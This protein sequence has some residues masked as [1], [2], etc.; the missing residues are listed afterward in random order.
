MDEKN[1]EYAAGNPAD[2]VTDPS[3]PD[4]PSAA[5]DKRID[6]EYH[7]AVAV[8]SKVLRSAFN[9]RVC[10]SDNKCLYPEV[11][12]KSLAEDYV[13]KHDEQ[14]RHFFEAGASAERERVNGLIYAALPKLNG[15][16]KWG[17]QTCDTP[18]SPSGEQYVMV[19]TIDG[20]YDTPLEA[21]EAA[22][23]DTPPTPTTHQEDTDA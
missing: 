18:D 20:D 8:P 22:V 3:I 17:W 9:W 15:D 6:G 21:F 23:I 16:E 1:K 12:G 5:D 4:Q 14:A 13:I 2:G 7:Y 11:H 10:R 19:G